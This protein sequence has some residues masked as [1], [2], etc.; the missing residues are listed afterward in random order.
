VRSRGRIGRCCIR[1]TLYRAV[2]Q[3]QTDAPQ[4][5]TEQCKARRCACCTSAYSGARCPTDVCQC[6]SRETRDMSSAPADGAM[7]GAAWAPKA[8]SPRGYCAGTRGPH[9]PVYSGVPG[10][11]RTVPNTKW[12]RPGKE[13]S[14]LVIS[15]RLPDRGGRQAR[16]RGWCNTACALCPH[17]GNYWWSNTGALARVIHWAFRQESP[18]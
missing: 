17:P 8:Y 13:G 11:R 1:G 3:S 7:S 4:R 6:L 10:Q 2:Y 12:Q 9:R 5:D 18:P 15:G 14:C 16:N